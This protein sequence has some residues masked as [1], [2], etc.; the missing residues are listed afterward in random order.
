[1][2]SSLLSIGADFSDYKKELWQGNIKWSMQ[3]LE[4]LWSQNTL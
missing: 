4:I 1:M 3:L 2:A